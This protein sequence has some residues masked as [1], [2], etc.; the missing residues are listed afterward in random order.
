MTFAFSN[1]R[2]YLLSKLCLEYLDGRKPD[3]VYCLGDLVGYNVWPNEGIAEI[4]RWGIATL[5]GN[6]DEKVE[7]LTTTLDSLQEPGKKYAYH[8]ISEEGRA[9][10]KTL[11]AHIQLATS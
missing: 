2:I 10:L 7:K 9:Y 3:A 6:H 8:L 1:M 4:R 11:P 5:K